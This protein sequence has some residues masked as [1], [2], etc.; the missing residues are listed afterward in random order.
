MPSHY[1]YNKIP[2]PGRGLLAR[3]SGLLSRASAPTPQPPFWSSD[4]PSLFPPPGPTL[5][6]PSWTP[7]PSPLNG[8]LAS[9][10]FISSQ[11]GPHPYLQPPPLALLILSFFTSWHLLPSES[12]FSYVPLFTAFLPQGIKAPRGQYCVSFISCHSSGRNSIKT[13]RLSK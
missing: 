8:G 11:M 5:F 4:L 3:P 6:S 9:S 1:F 7:S 13:S 2:T 10:A 12:I